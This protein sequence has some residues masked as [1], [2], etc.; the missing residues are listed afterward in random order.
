MVFGHH[1]SDKT[2]LAYKLEL[3]KGAQFCRL[4]DPP[5]AVRNP[6][7]VALGCEKFAGELFVVCFDAM[8]LQKDIVLGG[9][10]GGRVNRKLII[11]ESGKWKVDN[12]FPSLDREMLGPASVVRY[13]SSLIVR[14]CLCF[15]CRF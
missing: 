6:A 15:G 2:P 12:S 13:K 8:Y 9:T 4:P 1:A 14:S 10:V 11:F 5:F 7:V 3:Q